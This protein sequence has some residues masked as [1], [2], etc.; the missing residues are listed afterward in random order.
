MCKNSGTVVWL[1][2][3]TVALPTMQDYGFR[4]RIRV[5]YRNSP[6]RIRVVGV[7]QQVKEIKCKEDI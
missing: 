4:M 1:K 5:S 6:G 2:W 7:I 3:C